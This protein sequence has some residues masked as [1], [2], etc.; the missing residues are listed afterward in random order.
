MHWQQK[1][2]IQGD[3]RD[4]AVS[5]NIQTLL[6]P[7]KNK[8]SAKHQKCL[9]DNLGNFNTDWVF[10]QIKELVFS[11]V[12]CASVSYCG[13]TNHSKMQWLKSTTVLVVRDSV[14][15]QFEQVSAGMAHFCPTWCG[16]VIHMHGLNR[17]GCASRVRS[18][19]PL[20]P[21]GVSLGF[22]PLRMVAK[23]FEASDKQS[24][25]PVD[26]CFLSFCLGPQVCYCP[27]GQATKKVTW[28]SPESIEEGTSQG[29][30]Q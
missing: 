14:S 26:N 23:A 2:Q 6:D 29:H 20:I 24:K 25:A 28:S 15:H 9:G 16:W 22:G 1:L 3:L 21:N 30:E 18:M 5:Q 19:L 11:F 27:M 4:I 13:I 8:Q 7:D 10:D 12:V 17:K